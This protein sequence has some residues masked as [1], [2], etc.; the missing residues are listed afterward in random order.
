MKITVST[1]SPDT[2]VREPLILGFFSNERPP[3][4]YCGWVDWRLNGAISTEI[5]GG[6]IAGTFLEK[7]AYAF[8][9]RIRVS[10]LI[11]MGM[12][13]TSELTYDRLYNAGFEMAQTAI[14]MGATDLAV[15]V[16]GAGRVAL[17]LVGMS[18]ALITGVYDGYGQKPTILPGL[19]IEIPAKAGQV[20]EIRQGLEQ[21]RQRAG[22]AGIRIQEAEEPA[23]D[24]EVP[25]P[26]DSPKQLTASPS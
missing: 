6:R 19:D 11:L 26:I 5:A 4:G 22:V 10:R 15:P 7:I 18:E 2:L 20:G 13:T 14:G 12:G 8:P 21:F 3:K 16:P 24:R 17:K 9:H 25:V 1:A 23:A